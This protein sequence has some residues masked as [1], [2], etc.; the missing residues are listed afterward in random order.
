VQLSRRL[1]SFVQ[2]PREQARQRVCIVRQTDMYEPAV[3][4]EAEALVQAGFDVEVICMRHPERARRVTMDGVSVISLP[5]S[6]HRSG[7][8]RYALDYAWFFL[9]TT[10]VLAA[11]HLRRRY[12]VVQV[13]TMPDFL[14]F[15]A[16]V[17]R[18]AGSRVIAY[19]NE[20]TPELA[21]T[22]YGPGRLPR[23]LERIEQRAL[24]FADHAVTVTQ[25]L[26]QRY[27]ERGA[28]GDRIT[29]IL[30]G[31]APKTRL[32]DWI[33]PATKDT[34]EFT[35]ICHGAI[36]D[37][38]G[39][40]T[41]VEAARL[42]REELPDLRTVFT[43][44]GSSEGALLEMIESYG[45]EDVVRFE[46][47]V[48][49]RRL[50]DL[51]YSADVGVVAQKASPY[52]HLVHTNKMVDYWIFGLPVIA[53]RLAAVSAAYDETVL[54]YYDPGDPIALAAAICR[55]HDDPERRA[56]LSRN[57]RLAHERNGWSVQQDVY[58]AVYER[59]LGRGV[60]ARR[61]AAPAN[62]HPSPARD[63]DGGR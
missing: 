50:N 20:P 3:Q 63:G 5:A 29:V 2:R 10:G 32:G 47:W 11:R 38:Y 8:I 48:S 9:L 17:P 51:L 45:L 21:E 59:L 62:V 14:V 15:A 57:G 58:L 41:I 22:L 34:Q 31:A 56:E 54:E 19:M 18:L 39:Q 46:G 33:P 13:N 23:A 61:Q 30:N 4:R 37:R 42:L 24:A 53:S 35:V 49:G 55:L 28:R 12:A 60:S 43:G 26:K 7:R 6:L 40:D 16:M 25:E 1:S 44:R 36:E 27:V 52:S